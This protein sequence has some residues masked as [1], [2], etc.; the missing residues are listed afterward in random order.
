MKVKGKVWKTMLILKENLEK[1]S[2]WPEYFRMGRLSNGMRVE[3]KGVPYKKG[4]RM[5][6]SVCKQIG[7]SS[8]NE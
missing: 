6:M 5:H 2:I 3:T 8:K 1:N 7:K 4:M